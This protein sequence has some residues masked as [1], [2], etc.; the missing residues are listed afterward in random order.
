MTRSAAWDVVS[1]MSSCYSSQRIV[2]RVSENLMILVLNSLTLETPSMHWG[3]KHPPFNSCDF[4]PSKS[5]CKLL[6]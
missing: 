4:H 6:L 2:G 5:M 1:V 3:Y